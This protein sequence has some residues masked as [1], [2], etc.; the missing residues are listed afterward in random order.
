MKVNIKNIEGGTYIKI[1][2]N[3]GKD[4]IETIEIKFNILQNQFKNKKIL[5]KSDKIFYINYLFNIFNYLNYYK[6]PLKNSLSKNLITI[7]HHFEDIYYNNNFDYNKKIILKNTNINKLLK[8]AL[9]YLLN[10]YKKTN[11]KSLSLEQIKQKLIDE[12]NLIKDK[13]IFTKINTF[14]NPN[15]KKYEIKVFNLK[16]T[17]KL[18]S[19]KDIDINNPKLIKH[20]NRYINYIIKL[21]KIYKEYIIELEE[22]YINIIN[23][24]YNIKF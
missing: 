24:L 20:I 15:S 21:N 18:K 10:Q 5:N 13:S 7:I 8:D 19:I 12:L 22:Y 23:E 17:I 14:S 3:I 2:D 11:N 4:Y 1:L 16:K 6:S 9:F